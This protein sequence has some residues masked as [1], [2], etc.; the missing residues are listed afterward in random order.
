MM[1]RDCSEYAIDI[2]KIVRDR[3]GKDIPRFLV[4]WMERFIH[5]DFINGF[6]TQG[7][8]GTEF[9]RKCLEYLDVKIDVRGLENLDAATGDNTQ[10]LNMLDNGSAVSWLAGGAAD[11]ARLTFAS[12]HPLGGVDGI[13]L[14]GV[15][16][17]RTGKPVRLLV[18]DFLMNIKPIASLS[19]PVNKMGGQ[20]RNLPAQVKAIYESDDDILVFPAGKCSR[21]MNG[22][23][24]DTAWS[25][26]FVSQ[27]VATGRWIVPVRFFGENSKR[28]YR[29]ESIRERLGI[30][31]NIGMMLLPDELYRAR[32]KRFRIMFGKPISPSE[33]NGGLSPLHWAERIRDEVYRLD[34]DNKNIND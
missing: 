20:N 10:A 5:Q 32:H 13:A 2:G 27:S 34:W 29:V 30:R 17:E 28:F 6:L 15:I 23:I 8:E 21:K 9:C 7:Y 22:H 12:N 24:Q 19:V 25:K 11:R 26:S 3:S 33:M 14:L 31:F 1:Q 18:N 4:R 16:S